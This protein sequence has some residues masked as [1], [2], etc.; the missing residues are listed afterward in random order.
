MVAIKHLFSNIFQTL[1]NLLVSYSHTY[2]INIDILL[3]LKCVLT[4]YIYI[5]IY[6]YTGIH[7]LIVTPVNS[8]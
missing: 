6:M 5:Y 8:L 2:I 3:Y 4:L 1:I 7:V